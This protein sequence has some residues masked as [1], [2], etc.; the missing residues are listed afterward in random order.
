MRITFI[1]PTPNKSGGMKVTALY[2]KLLA[3]RGHDVCFVAPPEPPISLLSKA[4]SLVRGR[5]WPSDP[6]RLASSYFDNSSLDL[7]IIERAR[8]IRDADV[9]DADYVIATWWET[10]E[11]VESLSPRKGVKVYFIQGHEVFP[12]LPVERCHATYRMPLHKIVVARWLAD[13]MHEQYGDSDVSVVPNSVD[14]NQFFS[15]T[16]GKQLRPTVGFLYHT[17]PLKGAD[18]AI[19]AI[20]LLQ[21][22]VADL[23]IRSFGDRP[24]DANLPLPANTDFT[25]DPPQDQIRN[26]YSACDVWLTASQSEGFNLTALE[27]MACRTPV[28]STQTGWPAEAINN[29][30]NGYLVQVNDVADLAAKTEQVLG[31]PEP[32]WIQ[33]STAAYQ[34]ASTGSWANSAEL[35]EKALLYA[36]RKNKDFCTQPAPKAST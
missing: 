31:M 10:A 11:W 6:P 36:R 12:Y 16:R 22:R 35:F 2:G 34:T 5:G 14:R 25:C 26:I 7:R 32:E 13:V 23:R 4:K 29:G 28:V 3:A 33:M 24:P 21:N 17:A 15:P 20:R 8:P 1:C 30:E 27:A 18:R 19:Q 9:P